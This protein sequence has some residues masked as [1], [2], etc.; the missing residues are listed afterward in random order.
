M[1]LIFLSLCKTRAAQDWS[2]GNFQFAEPENEHKKIMSMHESHSG[3]GDRDISEF[4]S[5]FRAKEVRSRI[6]DPINLQIKSHKSYIFHLDGPPIFN[7]RVDCAKKEWFSASNSSSDANETI[8]ERLL[9]SSRPTAELVAAKERVCSSDSV[10]I[11]HENHGAGFEA[12]P[13]ENQSM[14]ENKYNSDGNPAAKFDVLE[15][16]SVTMEENNP[17]L[18]KANQLFDSS[19]STN[20]DKTAYGQP[21]VSSSRAIHENYDKTS[22][23]IEWISESNQVLDLANS[24]TIDFQLEQIKHRSCIANFESNPMF[25][26]YIWSQICFTGSRQR[27]H[28]SRPWIL[29]PR[30]RVP[31][32]WKTRV[33][34]TLR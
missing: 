2:M 17:D 28:P 25:D 27:R 26:N 12:M 34:V 11:L 15:D 16:S 14:S 5:S 24:E 22:I 1:F 19:P 6:Y 4:E 21:L 10:V 9:V 3:N 7:D 30:S 33:F 23:E 8:C 13:I 31:A 32:T 29:F 20:M 18:K